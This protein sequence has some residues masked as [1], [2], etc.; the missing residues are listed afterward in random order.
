[1]NNLGRL[2]FCFEIAVVIITSGQFLRM[3]ISAIGDGQLL[4]GGDAKKAIVKE[5]NS[6]SW[7]QAAWAW[8]GSMAGCTAAP[9]SRCEV[10]QPG[11][12]CSEGSVMCK[13]ARLQSPFIPT[14]ISLL[15]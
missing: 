11:C 7:R 15:P 3:G 6:G 1:M 12:R 10:G 5:A 9:S 2:L 13:V 14:R 4:R 8:A